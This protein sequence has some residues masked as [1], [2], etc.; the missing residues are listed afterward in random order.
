[1]DIIILLV[2][3]VISAGFVVKVMKSGLK[4]TSKPEVSSAAVAELVL[5]KVFSKPVRPEQ[6]VRG[7]RVNFTFVGNRYGGWVRSFRGKRAVIAT[8]MRGKVRLVHRKVH[9]LT[10]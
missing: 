8:I 6:M 2:V 9:Q 10:M 5:A 7:L 4:S 1:M 3:A